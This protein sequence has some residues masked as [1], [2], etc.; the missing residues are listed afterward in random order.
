MKA[1]LEFEVFGVPA[2]KGS[3]K[4]FMPKGARYPIVTH[5]NARTK[6]WQES[7]VAAAREAMDRGE[8]L[9]APVVV[10]LRFYLP[11]PKS[12]PKR[13][14]FPAKKPDIDKLMRCVLD[15]LT[16]A[17]VFLDD[18]QV[19]EAFGSKDFAAGF[20]DPEGSRGIP[21]VNVSVFERES[22]VSSEEVR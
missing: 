11:K 19:V 13:A 10:R 22:R 3:T 9:E 6:P 14:L 2:P 5:D 8:P 21:R 17:G 20:Q 4:A 15:G 12:A 1:A 7:V 16:R 18:A